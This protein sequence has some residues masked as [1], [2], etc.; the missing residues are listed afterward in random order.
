MED[1]KY[2]TLEELEELFAKEASK[3]ASN[4]PP[5]PEGFKWGPV[6]PTMFGSTIGRHLYAERLLQR[7]Y[8]EVDWSIQ[9]P[10]PTLILDFVKIWMHPLVWQDA[11]KYKDLVIDG[12]V[13]IEEYDDERLYEIN[14]IVNYIYV[15]DI[16]AYA[17]E[18]VDFEEDLPEIGFPKGM[19]DWSPLTWDVK[20]Y[21][22]KVL[23][24]ESYDEKEM[25]KKYYNFIRL[26]YNLNIIA[27]HRGGKR[28]AELLK[29]LQNEW[30][31]IKLWKTGF[32]WME[33]NDI[34]EFERMLFQGFDDVLEE[35]EKDK[36]EEAK[37]TSAVKPDGSFFAVSERMTYEM[38]EKELIR[39]ING[40]KNKSAACREILRSELVGYFVLS[41]KT[42]QEKADAINPWVALTEKKY[43][44]T[45]DDF[46]KARN[47]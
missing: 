9:C 36:V 43:V 25:D 17:D 29:M 41:D 33:E 20:S 4:F 22:D 47:S 38:C 15:Q 3:S 18:P 30:A 12:R 10:F 16:L 2:V 8:R 39:A 13:A 28:A 40:A 44:F 5:A 45:G 11:S 37:K 21:L 23:L 32:K 19:H 26:R 35:W 14:E 6:E 31:Q 34:S 1:K 7:D 46:R 24:G 42:D 27:K